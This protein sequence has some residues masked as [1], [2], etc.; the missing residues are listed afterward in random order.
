[1][2]L[3]PAQAVERGVNLV[4]NPGLEADEG[5]QALQGGSAY[6]A[7]GRQG[8]ALKLQ[9]VGPEDSSGVVQDIV[10]DPPTAEPLEL[11]GWSR[12]EGAVVGQDYNL[13]ADV[14][15]ADGTALWGQKAA[16]SPGT[17]G[18]EQARAVIRPEKPVRLVKLHLLFRRAQGTVWFDDVSLRVLPFELGEVQAYSAGGADG[19]TLALRAHA[20]MAAKWRVQVLQDGLEPRAWTGAGE[21][22]Q[23]QWTGLRPGPARLV[24]EASDDF[25]GETLRREVVHAVLAAPARPTVYVADSGRNLTREDEDFEQRS[26]ELAGARSEAESLQVVLRSPFALSGLK[27]S[28]SDLR[29]QQG[30]IPATAVSMRRAAEVAGHLDALLPFETLELQPWRNEIVW[31]TVRIPRDTRA[32]QYR[33]TVRVVDYGKA[34]VELPLTVIVWGFTLPERP[35]VAAVAGIG[36]DMF[37]TMY[38]LQEGTEE[39]SAALA[40][41]YALLKSYRVSPYFCRFGQAEPN[42]YAY[43]APWPIGDPRADAYLN[44]PDLAAYALEYPLGGDEAVLR[45]NLEYLKQKGWLDRGFFYLW[46]EPN[47]TAQY[48]KMCKWAAKIRGVAPEARI[49]TTYYCGPAD[50]PKKDQLD[51]VPELLR[52]S[53]DIFCMSQWAAG[54]GEAY[55]E[56]LKLQGR[57]E[58]WL[59]VC[60]GPGYPQ[61]NLYLGGPPNAQRAVMWRL[62]RQGATGFLYWCA[63]AFDWGGKAAEPVKFREGL[64]PG[65]GVLMY[66]GEA[67]GQRG[68]VPTVRLERLRDSLEDYEYLLA[69]ERANGRER[70]LRSLQT[71]YRGSS[72][73]AVGGEMAAWR[74]QVA[75]ELGWR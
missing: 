62:Y 50:G 53:T 59:Y 24:V 63:N 31:L 47:Q 74:E 65:D 66:P 40:E 14:L 11:S 33:G 46:D 75:T 34:A 38:G 20:S 25:R 26:A 37:R 30:T 6:D 16:F 4:R 58:W 68:P 64:P 32:G 7:A 42:H 72:D 9:G 35:G 1:M 10:L 54:T 5:W 12:A 2:A 22:A 28:V 45:R 36:D 55:R 69:L 17:H 48:E 23:A 15:Y 73:Y 70:A 19:C 29:G 13:Y 60:C 27:V 43:P 57:E 8:R 41:W 71:V 67:F 52:G 21:S 56:R 39:W 3:S 44:T 49:L 61:P 51:T 18:W